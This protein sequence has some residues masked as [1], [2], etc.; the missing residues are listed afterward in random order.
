MLSARAG[1]RVQHPWD[2]DLASLLAWVVV[3]GAMGAL[4][5]GADA[6]DV[7]AGVLDVGAGALPDGAGAPGDEAGAPDASLA[8]LGPGAASS[9]C[10]LSIDTPPR[11][12]FRP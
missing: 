11:G 9:G 4:P 1:C 12:L 5:G 3:E 10:A 8:A 6:L 2:Q 7:G